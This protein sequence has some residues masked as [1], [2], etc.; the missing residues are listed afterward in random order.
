MDSHWKV[1][2]SIP[3]DL[4]DVIQ[5]GI[6]EGKQVVARRRRTRKLLV[7]SAASVVLALGIVVGGIHVSPAFAAAVREI[8]VLGELV[9]IFEKNQPLAQG[10]SRAGEGT[11]ALTME[12][13]GDTEWIYLEFGQADASWYQAEFASYPKTVTITLPG[14]EGVTVLSQISRAQDS[15]QYIK[16]VCQLPVCSPESTA[17]QLELESDAEVQIQEYRQP[18]S[19]VIQLTPAEIQLDTVYSVR[20][21]SMDGEELKT[22]AGRYGEEAVR[23]LRD[24]SGT[25]FLEFGQYAA[26]EQAEKACQALGEEVI[27][28]KRTGNNVP[29]CFPTMQDYESSCFLD[30]YYQVLRQADSLEPVL[31]FMDRYFASASREEQEVMLAGLSG[32]LE[33]EEEADWE[34]ITSFYRLAGQ[35]PPEFPRQN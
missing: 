16:S 1:P 25:Y 20:T 7:R 5:R 23:I 17:I 13:D 12:R 32:L 15:S 10:G 9:Q 4:D 26:P 21:L 27:V 24:D 34:K 35:E 33:G 14:V 29:V 18:G 11:A 30:Q 19:L 28:E 8:P 3:E 31:D 2:V 22:A 6:R